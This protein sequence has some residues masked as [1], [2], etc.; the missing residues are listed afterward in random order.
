MIRNLVKK[1]KKSV[2]GWGSEVREL[3]KTE[4]LK[5]IKKRKWVGKSDNEEG[6]SSY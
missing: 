5:K 2:L 1:E 6:E 4:K 3:H